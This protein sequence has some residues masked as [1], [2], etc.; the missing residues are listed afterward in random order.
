M[1]PVLL[2]AF[3]AVFTALVLAAQTSDARAG[4][5]VFV[6]IGG[7]AGQP[8]GSVDAAIR[9]QIAA[10]VHALAR[11][12]RRQRLLA[13]RLQR[14]RAKLQGA[15][16]PF[17]YEDAI[18][19]LENAVASTGARA[20]GSSG[21]IRRLRAALQPVRLPSP[22][23]SPSSLGWD[24]VAVAEHY[25]G[26]RYL[27]GGSNPDSGFDCSGFV[28]YVFARLGL[29][30]PH[31]AAT[32]FAATPRVDPRRLQA[33]DLLFFEPR[34][35]GPGHVGIYVGDGQLVEA[36][37]TGDVVKLAPVSG[38]SSTLGFVGATRPALRRHGS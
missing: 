15:A 2:V 17:E 33:G 22:S 4:G 24:A 8:H 19:Q 20:R 29:T 10:E 35:D 13:A 7:S 25:L 9:R 21:V 38:L 12:R 34:S 14:L 23:R 18:A 28:K 30:L 3:L 36:P 6:V 31:Y 11:D 16:D 37:H 26:V 32:Q 1:R 5:P 27:W